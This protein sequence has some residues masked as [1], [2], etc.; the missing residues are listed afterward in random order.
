MSAE[1]SEAN[2]ACVRTLLH[3]MFILIMQMLY[4]NNSRGWVGRV[5]AWDTETGVVRASDVKGVVTC[6]SA[7]DAFDGAVIRTMLGVLVCM[8]AL[9]GVFSISVSHAT[10]VAADC[11]LF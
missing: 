3:H 9:G 2:K 11:I 1:G 7:V 10:E 8:V 4:I 6:V 5:A